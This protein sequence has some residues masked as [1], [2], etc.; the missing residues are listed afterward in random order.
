MKKYI[1]ILYILLLAVP[2]TAKAQLQET[3]NEFDFGVN[4]GVNLNSVS[5]TP[6]IKQSTKQGLVGGFTGR[7]ICEKYFSLICGVQVEA[8][9]SQ[10]GWTEKIDPTVSTD[11]YSRTMNYVEIP[12]LA[13]IGFGQDKPRGVQGF[14]HVGP[15]VAYL[16]SE[17]EKK[18]WSDN[19]DISTLKRTNDV[20]YQYIPAQNKFD[21][22]LVGGGGFEMKTGVGSF[23]MEGRYYFGLSDF[24]NIGNG[25]RQFT[26]AAHT[27]ISVRLAYL[28]N[29]NKKQQKA[30]KK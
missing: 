22:G 26:R 23:L 16:I 2:F 29:V 10:R 17:S 18:S 27:T 28:F 5:F 6:T 8:N 20:N 11:T 25:D 7:Y 24:F 30:K 15:Q 3:R 1:A 21:Y 9:F 4:A 19:V 12:F 14:I 13:H